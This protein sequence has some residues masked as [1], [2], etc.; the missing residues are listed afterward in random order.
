M[1]E[2]LRTFKDIMEVTEIGDDDLVKLENPSMVYKMLIE[3]RLRQEA[4]KWLKELLNKHTELR[5][6]PYDLQ[7]S[8]TWIKHFFNITDEDLK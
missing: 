1:E 4:I 3:G 5:L 6:Y 7:Y 8:I 2:K